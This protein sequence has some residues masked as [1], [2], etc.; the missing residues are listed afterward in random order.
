MRRTSIHI[1]CGGRSVFDDPPYWFPVRL[2][3]RCFAGRLGGLTA[4]VCHKDHPPGDNLVEG[5]AV[6]QTRQRFQ[7]DFFNF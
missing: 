3:K 5:Q 1:V 2:G 4:Q 6:L 7:L